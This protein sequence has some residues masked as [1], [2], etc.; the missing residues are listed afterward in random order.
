MR[1][2]AMQLPTPKA[3]SRVPPGADGETQRASP[4]GIKTRCQDASAGEAIISHHN[5][6]PP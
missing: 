6:Q 3:D 4:G 5:E 2:Q 1:S